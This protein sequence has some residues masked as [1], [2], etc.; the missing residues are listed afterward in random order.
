MQK[1][2]HTPFENDSNHPSETR[3]SQLLSSESEEQPSPYRLPVSTPECEPSRH[4]GD[5]PS[6]DESA[7]GT[8]SLG[9]GGGG[10]GGGEEELGGGSVGEGG[11]EAG[12]WEPEERQ[13][14]S[15]S[16]VCLR[17]AYIIM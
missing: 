1:V 7:A 4:S 12:R 17:V 10:G 3:E 13:R 5:T 16:H 8:S 11:G 14:E 15:P 2:G 9:G 6:G